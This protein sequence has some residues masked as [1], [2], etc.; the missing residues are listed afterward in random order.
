MSQW[1]GPIDTHL[2]TKFANNSQNQVILH[3]RYRINP[4]SLSVFMAYNVYTHQA[5]KAND[6][7]TSHDM[8]LAIL[9]E[10]TNQ[11]ISSLLHFK[12][13]KYIFA[14]MKQGNCKDFVKYSDLMI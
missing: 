3:Y 12:N 10:S 5:D 14:K 13:M 1:V 8:F 11:N 9:H 7:P 4:F 6:M 2:G